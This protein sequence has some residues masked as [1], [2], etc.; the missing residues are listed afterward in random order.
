MIGVK[1]SELNNSML[2]LAYLRTTDEDSRMSYR[3]GLTSFVGSFVG[4][5]LMDSLWL[6]AVGFSVVSGRTGDL[7]KVSLP[8]IS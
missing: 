4:N 3:R 1:D 5:Y 7:M 8:P 2:L 6:P